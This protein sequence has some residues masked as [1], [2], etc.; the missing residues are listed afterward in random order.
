MQII[1]I[2]HGFNSVVLLD[3]TYSVVIAIHFHDFARHG[4]LYDVVLECVSK[5]NNVDYVEEH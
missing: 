5:Y 4:R 3:C 2:C 1:Q